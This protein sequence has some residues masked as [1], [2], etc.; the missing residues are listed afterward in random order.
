VK[1]RQTNEVRV[2]FGFCG[3]LND[4]LER[5]Q[6]FLRAPE[7]R[8]WQLLPIHE[9]FERSLTRLVEA[10]AVDAVVGDFIS[11]AW[12]GDL[13]GRLPV[14]QLGGDARSAAFSSVSVDMRLLGR[15]AAAHLLQCGYEDFLLVEPPGLPA[16]LPLAEAFA[17]TAGCGPAGLRVRGTV[18]L[19]ARLRERKGR[20]PLGIFCYSDFLA[21]QVLRILR[22]EGLEVPGEAGV[23]GVGNRFW[24]RVAAEMELSSIPL[25]QAELGA[26]AAELLAGALS[27]KAPRRSLLPPGEVIPRESTLRQ[28]HRLQAFVEGVFRAN[29]ADTPPLDS[30]ARRAGMSRRAFERR[31]RDECGTTPHQHLLQLRLRESQRLLLESNETIARIG[32]RV[33]YPEPSRFSAFFRRLAGLSPQAWRIQ[34]SDP[35][36]PLGTQPE[37]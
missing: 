3:T 18:P 31:F 33:G 13:P 7:S 30:I 11:A 17:E 37:S 25:P 8:A 29:L 4:D 10:G 1:K 12:L 34:T 9:Q 35:F 23:L 22:A 16:A 32:E 6:G 15:R 20:G 24:D 2:V 36:R 21:R 26:R 28:H 5:Y 14:V 27:G 19:G